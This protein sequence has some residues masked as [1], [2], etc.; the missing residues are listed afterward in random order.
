MSLSSL[1]LHPFFL[2]PQT[3]LRSVRAQPPQTRRRRPTLDCRPDP[4]RPLFSISGV[5]ACVSVL[6]F[7]LCLCFSFVFQAVLMFWVCVSVMGFGLAV[8][9]FLLS[10]FVLLHWFWW[11]RWGY[12]YAVI[13][14]GLMVVVVVVLVVEWNIILL[15]YLYYFI[16]LKT[17]I[18]PLL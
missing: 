9:I 1:P 17:K 7:G 5:S 16:I 10:F 14:M 13:F 8:L 15:Y 11:S 2:P 12:G 3:H 18:K 4:S 6:C